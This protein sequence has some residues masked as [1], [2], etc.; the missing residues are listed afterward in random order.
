MDVGLVGGQK[1]GSTGNC[2]GPGA[3]RAPDACRIRI[4]PAATIGRF[5]RGLIASSSSPSRRSA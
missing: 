2:I 5:T 1:K 4:P 3:P